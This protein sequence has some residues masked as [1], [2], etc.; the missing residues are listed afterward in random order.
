MRRN[1]K[2]NQGYGKSSGKSE[3][4]KSSS[5][6]DRPGRDNSS[7]SD[8]FFKERKEG[9]E[10]SEKP[11]YKPKK[12]WAESPGRKPKPTSGGYGRGRSERNQLEDKNTYNKYS[13]DKPERRERSDSG[14]KPTYKKFSSENSYGGKS[15]SNKFGSKRGER[16]EASGK[17]PFKKSGSEWGEKPRGEKPRYGKSG[18]E[19]RE[20][21]DS[22]G[23]PPF[24]KFGSEWS[25]KPR[26]EKSYY[27]NSSSQ[28]EEKSASENKPFKQYGSGKSDNAD[29]ASY[30]TVYKGRGKD[31]KPRYESVKREEADQKIPAKKFFTK[32]R[33][34]DNGPSELKPT[35]DFKK[36]E[37]RVENKDLNE[38]IRLNKY[39]ANSGVCSRREADALI[40]NGLISVNGHVIKE[41]GHKVSKKD[42]VQYQGKT[43]NPEKPVY[44]LLNKPKDFIT[45]T[46]DP[47]ERKTVMS[48]VSSACD[49]RIF[50]VGR[51]DRNTTGLLLFTNDG[52]LA[53]KLAS[54]AN[55]I[56]KIYQVTLDLP[57]ANKDA[58]TIL[59][60]ITLE[61]G[62]VKVDDLQ[63]LSK[64]RTILG[65][66]IHIGKNRIVRR[67]FAH[68]GYEVVSLD[69]VV[70]AGLT[71]KDL[72]RGNYRF[73]GEKEVINL[74]FFS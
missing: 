28:R 48:L 71:K 72:S 7:S 4:F 9:S 13:S 29:S 25:E 54:P 61:D 15:S 62:P 31:Q 34:T 47:M 22:G 49:E 14:S 35:Y 46:D 26:G 32:N 36:Y 67:I 12:D 52:E 53:D 3:N 27:D 18:P 55:N 20:R 64:D 8:R 42:K 38:E 66:E 44:V 6:E 60:G 59:E 21:P 39:I 10:R 73:L 41:L 57:L 1:N 30:K 63:V 19:R 45:T 24:K 65:L 17:P 16:P 40:E 5:R 33:I 69:R 11:S 56:K 74:K 2:D 43:L 37:K 68:L 50:P 23:K 70:Y 58:D 51:L